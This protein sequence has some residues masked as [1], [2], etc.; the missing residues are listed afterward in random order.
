MHDWLEEA[1]R[2]RE[3]S[4]RIRATIPK[5]DAFHRGQLI[6]ALTRMGITKGNFSGETI[7]G[8][9]FFARQPTGDLRSLVEDYWY[10]RVR[11]GQENDYGPV[12]VPEVEEPEF[13]PSS[14][15]CNCGYT[16]GRTCGLKLDGPEGCIALHF[17]QDCDHD[18]TGEWESYTDTDKDGNEYES[19]GSVTCKHCG[20][21]AM[22]HAMLV[23]P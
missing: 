21:S 15:R 11:D 18:F 8:D 13:K 3:E 20:V 7:E 1:K 6:E 12:G 2:K 16:C 9:A 22:G 19:G 23:G 17:R 4:N 14:C 5:A 10:L